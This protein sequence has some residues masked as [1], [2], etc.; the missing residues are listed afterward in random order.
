MDTNK[1]FR[2]LDLFSGIG[3]FTYAAQRV[4]NNLET[5]SFCEHDNFCKKILNK[6]WPEVAIH[7]DIRTLNA[8]QWR[9]TVDLVVGG[10]PCQPAS[11]AGKRKGTADDRWL[12]PEA[13]R[14]LFE[15][16][17][18]CAIFENPLG[19]LTLEK[20]LVF[21]NLLLEMESQGY[22]V[23]PYIIPACA[24]GAVHRRDR[25][26]IVAHSTR[27]NDRGNPGEFQETN[28]QQATKRQK[29]R[30]AESCGT[31]QDAQNSRCGD[32]SERRDSNEKSSG[33]N[34]TTRPAGAISG[35]G[36]DAQNPVNSRMRGRS[37]GDS[38]GSECA[39]QTE[40]SDSDVADEYWQRPWPEVA[41]E[42]CGVD[43]S[44]TDRTHRLKALGNTIQWEVALQ[45]MR[46]INSG[47]L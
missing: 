15:S 40:G 45:I 38:R 23:Q 47:T 7:D 35:S 42:L 14:V 17:A 20:G 46:G 37:D 33:G 21:E 2:M 24:I 9:G 43:V 11:V 22:A 3:C 16:Q 13:L 26:W 32:T 30:I 5:V 6:H 41:T 12:W 34:G 1:N 39:L 18:E 25:V 4:W 29:K 44:S 10:P 19:I 28:E 8:R 27:N 36:G 31:D